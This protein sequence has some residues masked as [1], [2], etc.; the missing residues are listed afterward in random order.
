LLLVAV[1]FLAY[2]PAWFGEPIW[3]DDAHITRPELRSLAG[4]ARIWIQP[5]ATQ[6][7]Y[8]L[9]F[10]AFWVQYKL[11]GDSTLA[12]INQ[13]VWWQYLY[14]AAAGLL[15]GGCGRCGGTTAGCLARPR[16]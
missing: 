15:R 6:Q 10:S 11:W 9:A 13:A 7:Y 5:G 12:N 14:P 16:N 1:T 4:L 8:P 3:D 2:A